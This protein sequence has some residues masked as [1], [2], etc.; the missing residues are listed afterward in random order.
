M[1]HTK[2]Q[3]RFLDSLK[4]LEASHEIAWKKVVETTNNLCAAI[5]RG[6]ETGIDSN[7]FPPD[8]L[9]A[10]DTGALETGWLY[11]RLERAE[12]SER[13]TQKKIRMA[14]GYNG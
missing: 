7:S 4:N 11:S 1:S 6:E 8:I 3:L 10:I 14:L 5:E 12:K 13:D 2:L 9:R